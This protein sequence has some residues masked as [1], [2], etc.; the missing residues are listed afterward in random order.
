MDILHVNQPF[1]GHFTLCFK[2]HRNRYRR[3]RNR[4]KTTTSGG[5]S[6]H[7]WKA[8]G[9]PAEDG[10]GDGIK[11]SSHSIDAM[12]EAVPISW[13]RAK[14]DP[15]VRVRVA[16]HGLVRFDRHPAGLSFANALRT[17]RTRPWLT[18]KSMYY[19]GQCKLLQ[20][21]TKW[22]RV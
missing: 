17:C 12:R 15:F 14:D 13:S 7:N 4:E 9:W 21:R 22:G 16:H 20:Q 10:R 19:M 1:L 5:R 6:Y 18:W 11:W 3:W 2:S 8:P